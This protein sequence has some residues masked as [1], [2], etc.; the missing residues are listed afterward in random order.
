MGIMYSKGSLVIKEKKRDLLNW[1]IDR[2]FDMLV[3]L[4]VRFCLFVCLFLLCFYF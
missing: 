2:H 4:I 3:L 1:K